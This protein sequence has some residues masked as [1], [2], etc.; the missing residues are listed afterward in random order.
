MS[1]VNVHLHS[2]DN[3]G[4][5]IENYTSDQSGSYLAI[6]STKGDLT[7][8]IHRPTYQKLFE[9]Y[10]AIGKALIPLQPA[11][12]HCQERMERDEATMPDHA[13]AGLNGEE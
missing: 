6:E 2:T 7:I 5:K 13:Y 12:N 9:I 10:E 3:L 1:H 11:K 8:F 4:I